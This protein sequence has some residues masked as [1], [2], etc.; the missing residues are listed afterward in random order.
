MCNQKLSGSLVDMCNGPGRDET[1]VKVLAYPREG[2]VNS[3][4]VDIATSPIPGASIILVRELG[5]KL[6][7]PLDISLSE[8]YNDLFFFA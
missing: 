8:T 5:R 4:D 7:R 6:E 3:R 2:Y 1:P